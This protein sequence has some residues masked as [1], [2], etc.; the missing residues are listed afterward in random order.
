MRN[1]CWIDYDKKV[2]VPLVNRTRKMPSRRPKKPPLVSFEIDR[3]F[4]TKHLWKQ[5]PPKMIFEKTWDFLDSYIVN[6]TFEPWPNPPA[7]LRI[8]VVF[9]T[10]QWHGVFLSLSRNLYQSNGPQNRSLTYERCSFLGGQIVMTWSLLLKHFQYF[11]L[12]LVLITLLLSLFAILILISWTKH[13]QM[14]SDQNHG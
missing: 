12:Q 9:F 5:Q 7:C 13:L 1:C 6:F 10:T 4:S 2:A 14:S 3:F 11:L 8:G